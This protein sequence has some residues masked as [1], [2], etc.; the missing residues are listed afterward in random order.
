MKGALF[1]TTSFS[2]LIIDN[3]I[4]ENISIKSSTPL[5]I[6]KNLNLD[7]FNNCYSNYDYLFD[8]RHHIYEKGFYIYNT[9]FSNISTLFKG[10]YGEYIIENS[11]FKNIKIKNSLPAI[12][13]SKHT[14][15]RI[16]NTVFTNIDTSEN[17]FS[18]ESI[19]YFD[20]VKLSKIMINSKALLYTQYKDIN[21][22]N[23]EVNNITCIGD[24]GDTSLIYF[25]SGTSEKSIILN[26]LNINNVY[27][28]GS[29]IK[30][31]GDNN[32]V[33]ME[34][35]HIYDAT[36]TLINNIITNNINNNRLDSGMA[37]FQNDLTV[38]VISSNFTNNNSKGNGGA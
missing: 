25:D 6:N 16:S 11:T 33:K 27:S 23:M 29:L 13:N 10:E 15:L 37:H 19:L 34:N 1:D 38:S 8:F 17:I 20:N 24:G 21:I 28:N 22:N 2:K 4:L 14:I 9:T 18:K 3:S 32:E 26:N 12:S 31:I 30:I 7:Y 35:S 36:V 5:I